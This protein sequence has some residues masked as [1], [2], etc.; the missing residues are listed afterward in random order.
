[1]TDSTEWWTVDQAANYLSVQPGSARGQLSRWKI[2]RKHLVGADGRSR[3]HYDAAALRAKAGDRPGAGTR[4][5]LHPSFARVP[6]EVLVTALEAEARALAPLPDELREAL[7]W[8][9]SSTYI[10][11][12]WGEDPA[13][14]LAGEAED[15]AGEELPE[16]TA[17]ALAKTAR[18]WN[19]WQAL[20]AIHTH[21]KPQP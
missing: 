7:R 9:L 12:T 6:D 13:E 15:A 16:E 20:A 10:D 17:H 4:T 19:R 5:D 2:P 11:A 3:A 18:S 8:L 21:A 14:L 1:M